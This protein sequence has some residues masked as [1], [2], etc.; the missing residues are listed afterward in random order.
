MECKKNIYLH[1]YHI[2]TFVLC[3]GDARS[4]A[5]IGPYIEAA[6]SLGNDLIIWW[7]F[8]LMMMMMMIPGDDDGSIIYDERNDYDS[9]WWR[10]WFRV[11]DNDDDGIAYA[12]RKDNSVIIIFQ[13]NL[14]LANS[15]FD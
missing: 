12:D 11:N 10:W 6:Q 13:E 8:R 1:I 4:R 5:F 15:V 3:L 9:G 7:W 14:M 2:I